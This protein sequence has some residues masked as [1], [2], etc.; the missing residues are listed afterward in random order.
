MLMAEAGLRDDDQVLAKWRGTQ[1][2]L[3][4]L[5]SR[6]RQKRLTNRLN[7]SRNHSVTTRLKKKKTGAEVEEEL[8]AKG[9][10]G[11]RARSSSVKKRSSSLLG[12][13]KRDASVN[14]EAGSVAEAAARARSTSM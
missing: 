13:R 2:A 5:H 11:A 14:S 4:E 3:D 9:L 12:K 10:P 7:K 1:D 6:M 8:N